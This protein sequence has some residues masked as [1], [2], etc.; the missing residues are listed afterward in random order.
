MTAAM[1]KKPSRTVTRVRCVVCNKSFRKTRRDARYCSP[2][3]RQRAHRSRS[4]INLGSEIEKVRRD[5]WALVRQQAEATGQSQS[6]ILTAQSQFVD[7]EGNVYMGGDSP[8]GGMGK[9]RQ[10]VGQIKSGR[11]GWSAWGLEAAGPPFEPP[12]IDGVAGKELRKK[13]RR[14]P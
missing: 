7:G 13:W 10:L 8:M 5:Y 4:Q 12:P 14:Q 11:P 3:C 1:N 9:N 2:T 6:Q